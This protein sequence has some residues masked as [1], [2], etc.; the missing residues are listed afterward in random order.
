MNFEVP[1]YIV[2]R[3][4]SRGNIRGVLKIFEEFGLYWPVSKAPRMSCVQVSGRSPIYNA[5]INNKETISPIENSHT[6]GH[7]IGNPYPHSGN[8]LTAGN[9]IN[10]NAPFV[11]IVMLYS[12][13]FENYDLEALNSELEEANT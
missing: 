7:A 2:V 11:F 12:A 9:V 13:V 8:E 6:I 10:E 5:C 1:D 4:S 3:T